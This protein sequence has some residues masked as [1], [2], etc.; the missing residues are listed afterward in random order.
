[1]TENVNNYQDTREIS[2]AGY[3]LSEL[4]NDPFQKNS[5]L[6]TTGSNMYEELSSDS[7][8]SVEIITRSFGKKIQAKNFRSIVVDESNVKWFLTE[9]GIVSFNGKK[10]TLHNKNKQMP[11]NIKGIDILSTPAGSKLWMA[12]PEGASLAS[13][14]IG[15]K[16]PVNT[17]NTDYSPLLS[18]NVISVATGSNSLSWFGTENGISAIRDSKWL[19]YAYFDQYP[20]E[21]FSENPITTLATSLDGD[22]LYV[23]TIGLGVLRVFRNDVDGISGASD[24]AAWGPIHMPSDNIY[25][26]CIT[27]DGTQWFGTDMGV[28]RHR[29]YNTLADWSVFDTENGLVNNY[30]QAIAA[31]KEGKIWFGTKGGVSVY[32]GGEW[33]SITEDDGLNSNN[34]LSIAVDK[35]GTVWLGTDNGVSSYNKGEITNYN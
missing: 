9:L 20:K 10:W 35:D 8:G 2:L 26:I 31:D 14:P 32:D 18:N 4:T 19:D 21:L 11:A 17:F 15:K 16:N 33:T 34:V 24:Y 27:P 7:E 12:T 5:S 23:A 25:S 13:L 28:A 29:G 3:G 30:V 6:Q 1:M 22:S